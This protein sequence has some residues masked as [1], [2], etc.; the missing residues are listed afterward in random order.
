MSRRK[1]E[2][3][4]TRKLSKSRNGVTVTVS[5]PIDLV[6]ELKWRDGQKVVITKHGEGLKISDWEEE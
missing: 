3:W 2:E 6:R 1:V 5:L 4:N